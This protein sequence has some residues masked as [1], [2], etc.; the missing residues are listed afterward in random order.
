MLIETALN[1]NRLDLL[2]ISSSIGR[3]SPTSHWIRRLRRFGLALLRQLT[4]SPIVGRSVGSADQHSIRR[5]HNA[6]LVDDG[7]GSVVCLFWAI[8][9][10]RSYGLAI[11]ENGARPVIIYHSWSWPSSKFKAVYSQHSRCL[12]TRK[13]RHSLMALP[14]HQALGE[15]CIRSIGECVCDQR[16]KAS[17]SQLQYIFLHPSTRRPRR[18]S[19]GCWPGN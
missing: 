13:H 16:A 12:R 11:S 17:I 1:G 8:F 9:L 3:F 4:T 18:L 2:P 14:L 10:M 6:G 5:S 7:L 19:Q 15:T